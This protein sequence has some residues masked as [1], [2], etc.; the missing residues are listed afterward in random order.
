MTP[1][2][3]RSWL[4]PYA[5]PTAV[6]LLALMILGLFFDDPDI[7]WMLVAI[8][9]AIVLGYVFRPERVWVIPLAV[10]LIISTTIVIGALLGNLE[11][12]TSPLINVY[13]L[14]VLTIGG[15]LLILTGIGKMFRLIVDDRRR[16]HGGPSTSPL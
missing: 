5:L 14:V 2:M 16:A 13:P 7:V 11:P 4:V 1:K 15:P 3:M 12:N 10:A 8:P 9:L 6:L